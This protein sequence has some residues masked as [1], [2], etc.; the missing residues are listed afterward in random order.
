MTGSQSYE[1]PREANL[2]E[3]AILRR[4][5][6]APQ[7]TSESAVLM[8][9]TEPSP[10][11]ALVVTTRV[12]GPLPD[13]VGAEQD[14]VEV[15]TVSQ[16]PAEHPE[17]RDE[18]SRWVG[19]STFANMGAPFGT[20]LHGVQVFWRPGRAAILAA[21]D[22]MDAV[23][24]AVVEFC[25]YENELRNLEREIGESWPQLEAH[26]PLAHE[27]TTADL[28]RGAELAK[29]TA[30]TLQ[31][32]MRHARLQPHLNRTATQMTLQAQE[33]GQRLR[34][35]CR[36][37]DRHE[38]LDGQL[39]TFERVC[40]MASQRLSDFRAS[41]GERKLEWVIIVLLAAEV[42]L[43]LGELLWRLESNTN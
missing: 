1:A 29:L 42:L 30:Q 24:K 40:E 11:K 32:R 15:V 14:A 25:F 43:L 41:Q 38:T 26:M 35:K 16:P 19:A 10:R 8:E 13:L 5:R 36:A 20:V 28:R 34:E 4:I 12:S 27:A 6:F 21:A 22:R 2:S 37:E 39:A 7:A 9:F 17:L 33:L 18:L 3:H 23:L 31:R